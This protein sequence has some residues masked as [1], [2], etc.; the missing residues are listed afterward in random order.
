MAYPDHWMSE[1]LAKNDIVS[2]VSTYVDLKPKGRRLWGLCPVHGEKTASFS[3]SPDRQLYYCFGCHIGGSV[4]QFVMDVEHLTFPEAVEFLANRAGM[5]MPEE[6]N[7]AAMQ[8]ARAKRERLAEACKL[9][10]RFYM[11]TLLGEN[12]AAGRAYL[13]KRGITSGSV[14]RFGIGYAPSEWEALKRHLGEKGFSPEEL[15]E[16]GL[17]VKNEQSGRTYDA[18]RGRLIFPIIA[19]SGRVIGF[20]ARVLNNEEKP[21]YINTGDTPLYNKRNNLYGLNLQKN[22]KL[23]DLVMVEGYT[24]VIG[25]FEAGVTNAVASLGTALTQ[26]QARLLK[27][28]VNNV[29]IAYDGDTAGQNATIRGLDILMAEGLNVRVIVFPG[30]QDPDEFVRQSGKEAF[31]TLK[32]E[33]LSLNAFKLEAMSR[34][35][36]MDRE[37]EREQ[38][39]MEACRF[40]ATLTPVERERYYQQLSK[41][42][43]YSLET[44]RAQGDGSRP[45]ER[46]EAVSPGGQKSVP[47]RKREVTPESERIRAENALL[48]HMMQSPAAARLAAAQGLEKQFASAGLNAF[49]KALLGVYDRGDTPNLPLLLSGMQKEDAER[50]SAALRDE[51]TCADPEKAA[52][53]CLCRIERCD[54]SEQ[55]EEIKRQLTEPALPAAQRAELLRDMQTLNLRMRGLS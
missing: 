11:E 31:D 50:V 32:E 12:G 21:K 55:I 39:A 4:I 54:L 42:T 18:Y 15:A 52:K 27:R 43:G 17:L 37:N 1:L 35:Y 49:A 5:A 24:D 38:F 3:V 53:D 51:A 26:Q 9:A 23:S 30:G 19:A 45:F 7:D 8:R 13:K 10:A 22:G 44:L 2:V 46:R 33:A 40:I 48:Y 20:G 14:K 47:A 28:Y 6:V 34:N 16:A 25:L 41:K 29:Y 36:S